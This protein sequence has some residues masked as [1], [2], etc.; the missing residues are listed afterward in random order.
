MPVKKSTR[1]GLLQRFVAAVH[2]MADF[3]KI[4]G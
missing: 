2:K 3:S 1:L 4:E